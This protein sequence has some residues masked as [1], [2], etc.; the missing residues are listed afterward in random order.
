MEC[1]LLKLCRN[2]PSKAP[3]HSNKQNVTPVIIIKWQPC[4]CAALNYVSGKLCACQDTS[5]TT[6]SILRPW[7]VDTVEG[8]VFGWKAMQ[9]D[10]SFALL[11]RLS[12]QLV[13]SSWVGSPIIGSGFHSSRGCRAKGEIEG[14]REGK[15]GQHLEKSSESC[16]GQC[17][18][19]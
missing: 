17:S 5:W 9:C 18:V 15:E 3:W 10:S 8:L 14:G 12:F 4:N 19:A 16:S 7:A 6:I 1:A 13:S 11:H 2:T